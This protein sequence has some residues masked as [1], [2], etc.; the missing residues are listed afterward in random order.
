MADVKRRQY[1]AS[2]R[3]ERARANRSAMLD[4]AIELLVERGYAETTLALVAERAQVAAPTVYKAFGNKPAMVKAAF[5]YAAAGDNDPAPVYQRERAKRILSEP[6]PEQKLKIYTDG[7]LGTLTR[8]ARLQLVARTAAEIDPEMKDV[9]QHM[10]SA[11]LVGMGIIAA[12]LSDGGHLRRGVSKRHAQD[13]LWAYT[14]P[15]LYQLMVL[16]RGW[17]GPRYRNWVFHALVNALLPDQP[18]SRGRG[19]SR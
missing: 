6:N 1:D 17:S 19:P 9:W 13:V 2:R 8:S 7:L 12:N 3:Q 4:V 5:D 11:R 15:E 18:G 16:T 10:T 14:S